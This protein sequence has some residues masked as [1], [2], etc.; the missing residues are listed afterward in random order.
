MVFFK[1]DHSVNIRG[2]PRQGLGMWHDVQHEIRPLLCQRHCR[3]KEVADRA[4]WDKDVCPSVA[5]LMS[6]S[7]R[8]TDKVQVTNTSTGTKI[9]TS[10]IS[11]LIQTTKHTTLCSQNQVQG[12]LA[13]VSISVPCPQILWEQSL[14]LSWHPWWK[15][16]ARF[17]RRSSVQDGSIMTVIIHSFSCSSKLS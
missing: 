12:A 15:R 16:M 17:T 3:V 1:P 8:M 2:Q 13:P 14:W 6:P 9:A 11:K 4:G 5:Q 7:S 10:N